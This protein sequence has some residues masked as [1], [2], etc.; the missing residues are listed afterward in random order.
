MNKKMGKKKGFW[1]WVTFTFIYAIFLM[2][3]TGTIS[4]YY[5]DPVH[6]GR[7]QYL[8]LSIGVL[9]IGGSIFIMI[10]SILFKKIRK[11]R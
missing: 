9:I 8:D 3:L 4:H 5:R 10:A 6:I 2:W 1:K 11:K 7:G